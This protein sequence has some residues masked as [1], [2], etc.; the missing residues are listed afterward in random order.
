MGKGGKD[1]PWIPPCGWNC[2]TRRKLHFLARNVNDVIVLAIPTH[3]SC[4][5]HIVPTKL[6]MGNNIGLFLQAIN[7]STT[8]TKPF[9]W[10]R[11]RTHLRPSLRPSLRPETWSVNYTA[12][13][14]GKVRF[15]SRHKTS[16]S[17]GGKKRKRTLRKS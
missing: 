14:A 6:A 17:P 5:F 9:D 2:S 1:P 10:V 7:E 12:M 8:P 16:N 15:L 4:K 11:Y 3:G 13:Q